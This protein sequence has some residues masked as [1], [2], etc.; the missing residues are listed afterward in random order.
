[1]YRQK[2]LMNKSHRS[3]VIDTM[4]AT[5]DEKSMETEQHAQRLKNYSL[6]LGRE[7]CLSTRELDEL[8]LFAIL[9]DIGKIGIDRDILYEPGV[10]SREQWREIK[11]H[12]EI[13]YRI[14]SNTPELSRVAEYILHH[15]ERWDGK[16]YPHGL[17]GEEIPLL[18]RILALADAFDAM[19][20]DRPYR[21]AMTSQEALAEIRQNAGSQFDPFLA[22]LFIKMITESRHCLENKAAADSPS[23]G[24]G[25]GNK[26]EII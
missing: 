18:C 15:H 4:L 3:T 12:P 21:A 20:N 22:D 26:G 5:L 24:K 16:G 17:R 13:G 23:G 7:L 8:E 2:L 9:H 11:K 6:A 1:M 10:L 14:A 19:T 25:S